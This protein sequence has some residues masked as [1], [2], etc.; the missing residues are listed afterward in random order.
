MISAS[1]SNI[2]G[3]TWTAD[4][5]YYADGNIDEKEI[6][7]SDTTNYSYDNDLMTAASGAESF[8]LTWN[9]NGNMTTGPL[10]DLEYNW[11]GNRVFLGRLKKLDFSGGVGFLKRMSFVPWQPVGRR[12][13]YG[14]GVLVQLGEVVEGVGGV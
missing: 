12:Y 7:S 10:A 11:D 3:S 9:N 13:R 14:F 8:S 4:C 2:N 5:S 6:N 1:I